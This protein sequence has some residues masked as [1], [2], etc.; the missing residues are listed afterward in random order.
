MEGLTLKYILEDSVTEEMYGCRDFMMIYIK[1]FHLYAQ[2][3]LRSPSSPI[4]TRRHQTQS[5]F[6]LQR[7]R[8][9][10]GDD[11]RSATEL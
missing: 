9:H 6:H 8:I 4:E 11:G 7:M 10:G 2:P 1:E 3:V 5:I